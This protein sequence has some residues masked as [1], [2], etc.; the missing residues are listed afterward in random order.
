MTLERFEK[1]AQFQIIL[2]L[3]FGSISTRTRCLQFEKEDAQ[4]CVMRDGTKMIVRF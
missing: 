4:I 2:S 1:N 3:K